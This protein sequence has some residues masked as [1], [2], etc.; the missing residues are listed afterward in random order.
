M[1]YT[2]ITRICMEMY[3]IDNSRGHCFLH[4]ISVSEFYDQLIEMSEANRSAGIFRL[5]LGW[6]S[7]VGINSPDF[8]EILL[9]STTLIDK[10]DDYNFLHYWLGFGLLTR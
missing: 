3:L 4:N 9:R 2:N 8:V 10:S 6:W 5:M 1:V 7:I